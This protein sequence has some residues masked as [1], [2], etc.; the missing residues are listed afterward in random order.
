MQLA[1]LKDKV[2]EAATIEERVNALTNEV[3]EH[4]QRLHKSE[5]EKMEI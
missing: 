4:K 5:T 1:Q 2:R 3:E